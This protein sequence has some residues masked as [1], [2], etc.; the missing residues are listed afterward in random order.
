MIYHADMKIGICYLLRNAIKSLRVI[1][2]RHEDSHR[3]LFIADHLHDGLG[4]RQVLR[5]IALVGFLTLSTDGALL[6]RLGIMKVKLTIYLPS[7]C[8]STR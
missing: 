1:E 6:W 5:S 2:S 3:S 7:K 4:N 8:K